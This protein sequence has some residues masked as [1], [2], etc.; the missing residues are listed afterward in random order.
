MVPPTID[1]AL[2]SF[3]AGSLSCMSKALPK[4]GS[5]LGLCRGCY[6]GPALGLVEEQQRYAR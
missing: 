4:D 6:H 1:T 2:V 5:A 3:L